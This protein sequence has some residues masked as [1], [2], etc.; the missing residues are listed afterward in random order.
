MRCLFSAVVIA[1]LF[2]SGCARS[3]EQPQRLPKA[4]ISIGGRSLEVEIASANAQRQ[5]GMMYRRHLAP[6]EGML[7]VFPDAQERYFYM[8][9]TYSAL[10][11]A[12][13]APGGRIVKITHMEP[14]TLTTHSSRLPAMYAL[15]MPLGWFD[16]NK[17]NEGDTIGIPESVKALD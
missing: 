2:A 13:I 4:P 7:F 15:E 11:I 3:G 8:K 16:K 14:L 17:V 10:S 12:F 5:F 1:C 9:N 6:D